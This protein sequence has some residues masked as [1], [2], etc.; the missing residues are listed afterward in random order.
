MS[1]ESYSIR[2]AWSDKPREEAHLLNP[3]FVGMLLCRMVADY[4]RKAGRPMPIALAFLL[5]PIVL[6]RRTREALPKSTVTG[7]L[8]WLQEHKDVH[9]TFAGRMR[10]TRAVTQE[11]LMFAMAHAYLAVD[12]AALAVGRRRIPASYPNDPNHTDE[13]RECV[14]RAAFVGRWLAGA[15][16]DHTIFAAWGVAP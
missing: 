13:T 3:A 9:V 8:P 11:A 2:P 16:T 15:G 1:D 4:T 14:D 7:V 10:V 5:A 6:H 12:G